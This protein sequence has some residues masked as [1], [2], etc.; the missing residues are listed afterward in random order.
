MGD[1]RLARVAFYA[2]PLAGILH[3]SARTPDQFLF[4]PLYTVPVS[5]GLLTVVDMIA[6]AAFAAWLGL[7][8]RAWLRGRLAVPYFCFMLSH[9]AVFAVGYIVIDEINHG[10]LAINIWH[11]AQ[12]VLF[13]SMFNNRRFRG[14]VDARA[15]FL[16][17][18]SQNG[19]LPLYLAVCFTLSTAVYVAIDRYG[20]GAI[21]ASAGISAGV[22]AVIVYQTI[23][24]H[25]YIVDV[26]IWKLRKAPM[27]E[28]LGLSS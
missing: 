3:V 16:S 20:I 26:L 17:T 9:F 27:R 13:V 12:Y 1:L 25:H 5:A 22:A 8:F 7:Q 18:I 19:R 23:N 14:T 11:N 4:M 28:K 10:W 21:G 15:P 6:A 2:V 24:F